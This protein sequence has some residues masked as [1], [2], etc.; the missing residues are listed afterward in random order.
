M[1]VL[2]VVAD[3]SARG[4]R[5]GAGR[6]LA[7]QVLETARAARRVVRVCVVTADADAALLAGDAGADVA[8]PPPD[9]DRAGLLQAALEAVTAG[10]GLAP[11]SAVLLDC[12]FPLLDATAIDGAIRHFQRCGADSLVAVY[13]LDEPLWVQDEGGAAQPL[14]CG[15]H[16][17][18]YVETAAI[19]AVRVGLFER[20]GELPTGRVVLYEVPASVALRLD[21]GLEGPQAERLV[22]RASRARAKAL[23]RRV[24]LLVLDFDG[25]MTDNR[26]LVLEDGREAVLCS[27]GDGM[28]IGLLK[29]AGVPV[30][31]LSKEVNPVVG[32]RC[33][34]LGI[35]H[36][37][38][39]DDKL[40]ELRRMVAGQSLD[41]AEI[42]YMGNDV[43]DLECMQ[44][45]GVAI[46]PA[47]SHPEALR[48][49][50]LVTTAIG[51]FGAVREVCDLLLE[52]QTK[53][54]AAPA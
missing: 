30:A 28:G 31:V 37:Q 52:V 42:A 51:G 4:Q 1:D 24:R 46:A 34:K 3:L 35:P 50:D 26:V 13:P 15:G 11:A 12:R 48:V 33:R 25:V 47:D 17:R 40:A 53:R 39:I 20:T 9:G 49:A 14:D 18:R 5:D 2:A 21:G 29:G 43:N 19:A 10:N 6:P 27:R 22:A 45:A 16:E 36:T 23:L 32:A 54:V 41:L 38:G 8:A 44:A 7:L